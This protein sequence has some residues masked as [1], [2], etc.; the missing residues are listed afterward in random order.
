MDLSDDMENHSD[1][2]ILKFS[3]IDLIIEVLLNSKLIEWLI[4]NEAGFNIISQITFFL[5]CYSKKNTKSVQNE[6][7]ENEYLDK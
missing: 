3:A 7:E 1:F 2:K 4:F 5:N 6:N